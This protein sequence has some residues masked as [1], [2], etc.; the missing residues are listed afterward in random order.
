M[1]LSIGLPLAALFLVYSLSPSSVIRCGGTNPRR[2]HQ[3]DLRAVSAA[4]TQFAR[5][6]GHDPRSLEELL[7]D[8]EHPQ[9]YLKGRKLPKDAWKR[10]Y[11][12]A[13]A[14]ERARGLLVYTLGRDALPGGEGDQADVSNLGV[15]AA[16]GLDAA[17]AGLTADGY[18][19]DGN[20]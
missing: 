10:D 18:P 5:D 17:R 4:M 12:Y 15:G 11:A 20:R 14:D 7:G 8:D 2:K 9:R 13:S 16:A 1:A 19:G 6:R 3:A